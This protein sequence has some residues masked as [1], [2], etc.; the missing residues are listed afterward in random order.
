M[1]SSA[2]IG[3]GCS[4]GCSIPPAQASARAAATPIDA[5]VL[6]HDPSPHLTRNVLTHARDVLMMST[7][8]VR[9][10]AAGCFHYPEKG[11]GPFQDAPL[12]PKWDRSNPFDLARAAS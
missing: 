3:Y 12:Q 6:D 7:S 10:G 11:G 1:I 2:K 9:T 4:H 5:L 8:H